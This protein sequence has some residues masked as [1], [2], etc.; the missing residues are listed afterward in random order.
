VVATR[1]PQVR[2]LE[3]TWI[4]QNGERLLVL[5][6]REGLLPAP[7]AVPAIVG[8][9]ISLCDGSRDEA[10][11]RRLLE[12]EVGQPFESDDLAS[13]LEQLEAAMILDGPT[14]QAARRAAIETFRGGPRPAALAGSVYPADPLA[15]RQTIADFGRDS[16]EPPSARDDRL[17]AIVSPPIDYRR[18]GRIYQQVLE[19]AAP[20]QRAADTLVVFGTDHAGGPGRVTLTRQDFETPF[21]RLETDRAVVDALANALGED[22][23]FAEELHHR[24][25]HSIELALVWAA[26]R[27]GDRRPTIVPVL[28]GS[29]HEFTSGRAEPSAFAP[30]AATVET[31]AAATA[32]RRVVVIAAADL[33]HVGPAFGD[34]APIDQPG[35]ARLRDA[36]ERLLHAAAWGRPEEF[37]GLLRAEKDARRICGLP[38]I[39]L[40]L[41]LLGGGA[42]GEVVGYDQCPADDENGSLVS[43]AGMVFW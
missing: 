36:D 12:R 15:L 14:A 19:R 8:L 28:C 34:R 30:F 23:A 2:M 5:R 20:S 21:G 32:G 38:P 24:G 1:K 7:A 26:S 31:L 9:I 3:P 11:I 10:E 17:R 18:R 4:D 22:A 16:R 13:L 33:A 25:E 27:L 29:F 41:A 6:D 35:R 42:R 39:Y 40:T 37:F 43:I